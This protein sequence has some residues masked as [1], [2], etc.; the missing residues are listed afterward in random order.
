[1]RFIIYYQKVVFCAPSSHS[2][3]FIWQA[4]A[5]VSTRGFTLLDIPR[6]ASMRLE[7]TH[8]VHGRV[9]IHFDSWDVS[10]PNTS[11]VPCFPSI[12][13]LPRWRE[14]YFCLTFSSWSRA[15]RITPWS[16]TALL[17][18]LS[19]PCRC[20]SCRLVYHIGASYYQTHTILILS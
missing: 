6:E 7:K 5:F 4:V 11:M 18:R 17:R 14:K 8:D 20:D 1:M 13:I 15:F 19:F 10:L 12:Y 9:I 16:L 3:N 2:Y